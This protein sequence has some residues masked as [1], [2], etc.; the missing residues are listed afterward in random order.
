[1]ADL[2][3]NKI[4]HIV[5]VSVLLLISMAVYDFLR[6]QY[7]IGKL[8]KTIFT[9]LFAGEFCSLID[10]IFWGGSLDYVLLEHFFIFDLKDVYLTVFEILFISCAAFNYKGFR[11]L[12]G[13]DLIHAYKSYLHNRFKGKDE[14]SI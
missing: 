7:H 12:K 14:L 13:S 4:V 11:K 6:Y 5:C 10:K 2:G 3:I 9:F 8:E 1:M